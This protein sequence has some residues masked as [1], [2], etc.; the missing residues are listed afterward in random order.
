M[1]I[2]YLQSEHSPKIYLIF[3]IALFL[4]IAL[5]IYLRL[6][7]FLLQ[8]LMDDE[9][10]AVNKLLSSSPKEIASSFGHADYSIPLTLFYWLESKLF[11]L[12]E[13]MM[14]W[15]MML[16]GTIT[17]IS[18]PIYAKKH[19]HLSVV[20]VFAFFIA[21]SPV[22][23]E[24]SRIARPY[25]I[26]LFLVYFS[27]FLF[28]KFYNSH[29][30]QLIRGLLYIIIASL[31]V[32]LHLIVVF[33]IA[34]PFALE[35]TKAIF[36]NNS[37]KKQYILKLFKLGIPTLL[38][39]CL[40]TVPPLF[41]DM[42]AISS[43]AGNNIPNIDTLLGFLH[44]CFGT[45]SELLVSVLSILCLIGLFSLIKKSILALNIILGFGLTLLVIF[46]VQP[47]WV[48]IPITFTRYVLPIMPLI[49]LSSAIGLIQLIHLCTQSIKNKLLKTGLITGIII[50]FVY[51]I[52]MHSPLN[53]LLKTPNSNTLHSLF[54]I[55]YRNGENKVKNHMQERSISPFWRTLKDYPSNYKIAVAPWFFESYNWDA[56]YWEENSKH[57]IIPGMLIDLCIEKRQ[58]EVPKNHQ[59]KFN[60]L[61]Y[62]ADDKDLKS[63][64]IRWIVYQKPERFKTEVKNKNLE[65][66]QNSLKEKYGNPIFEDGLIAVYKTEL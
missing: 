15:P 1:N 19:F 17:L 35:L 22:L 65:N 2:P 42:A 51:G 58:G 25:A 8:T 39:I 18:F 28:Y 32:W 27:L 63:K 16:I 7:Q 36:S 23:I 24:Y 53:A 66:C 14:R 3:N 48:H 43:K 13:L 56:P 46:T 59:F 26:T 9:W 45:S 52:A 38:L 5:G 61:A 49:L 20:V 12:S 50:F 41:N 34:A 29:E 11:G 30:K 33:F 21:V 64:N 31:A 62:L 57:Y 40:L 60:N 44:L 37:D 10:H 55:D 6:N 54:T 4:I 47:A